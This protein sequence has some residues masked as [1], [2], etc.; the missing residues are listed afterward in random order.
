MITRIDVSHITLR[1]IP[2]TQDDDECLFA[3]VSFDVLDELTLPFAEGVDAM[4]F[5]REFPTKM[6]F[7]DAAETV[8]A[9]ETRALR[10]LAS[11]LRAFAEAAEAEA[12]RRSADPS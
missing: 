3:A 2:A 11:D 10:S 12:E 8:L 9:A 7:T 5:S 4:P 6:R 1:R